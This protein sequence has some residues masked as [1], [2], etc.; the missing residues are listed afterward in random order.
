MKPG[1]LG[2]GEPEAARGVPFGMPTVLTHAVVGASL[3]TLAPSSVPRARCAAAFAI[4]S[5]FPDADVLAFSLGIPYEHHFGHRGLSHSLSFA[6][7][8]A[9]AI[10]LTEY[11]RAGVPR[12]HR[13]WLTSLFF[14][15]LASHGL[16]DSLTNGGLG[17]GLLLPFREGRF[18]APWR[19]L[20]V[21]P[22]GVQG[23]FS[24][25]A[26]GVL[27]SELLVVLLP[28]GALLATALVIRRLL[29]RRLTSGC[30]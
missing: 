2:G 25:D 19:P 20:D 30:S 17:V 21:S 29:V 7:F 24:G 23:F 12:L 16:L 26:S 5:M 15:A 14:V 27:R 28:L 8:L 9:V 6:L 4:A 22:I 10:G 11:R 3:S 13:L 1:P 18:F